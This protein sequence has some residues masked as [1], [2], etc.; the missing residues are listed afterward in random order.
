MA[1]DIKVL[2]GNSGNK[3]TKLITGR[4]FQL[5]TLHPIYLLSY[6]LCGYFPDPLRLKQFPLSRDST[7]KEGFQGFF[8]YD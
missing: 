2:Y 3:F 4:N 5:K 7:Y 6:F 1:L 8:T